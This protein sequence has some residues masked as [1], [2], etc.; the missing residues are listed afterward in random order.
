MKFNFYEKYAQPIDEIKKEK[1][2]ASIFGAGNRGRLTKI[3]LDMQNIPVK[4]FY[5][6]NPQKVG[7]IFCGVP[8]KS[9]K[10]I[11]SQADT[12][13]FNAASVPEEVEL[14]LITVAESWQPGCQLIQF[15]PAYYTFVG[16]EID[17][18]TFSGAKSILY[19]IIADYNWEV[20]KGNEKNSFRVVGISITDKCTLNCQ[21]CNSL[22]PYCV[23]PIDEGEI[24]LK[25][26]EKLLKNL[27]YVSEIAI[28]GGEPFL[29]NYLKDYLD[30]IGK[31]SNYEFVKIHT[32]GTV[33]PNKEQLAA[34]KKIGAIVRISN[35]G[36]WSKK[37]NELYQYLTTQEV[38]VH[39]VPE[40]YWRKC[41][42][43]KDYERTDKE[44]SA[45]FK[46]C[47]IPC[48]MF[49]RG[50]LFYCPFS[51]SATAFHLIPDY[52]GD[53]IDFTQQDLLPE[54]VLEQFKQW[55][56]RPYYDACRFCR[57][58]LADSPIIPAAAQTKEILSCPKYP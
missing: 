31:F 33:I 47:I 48:R 34:I 41:V 45:F 17:E 37:C 30:L 32:N 54:R 23:Q 8:V 38:E 4:C 25:A 52:N 5:D 43:I 42:D 46:S 55:S 19:D 13:I 16:L 27:H 15:Y 36:E 26:V 10:E 29:S 20:K 14:Q 58:F 24:Q 56:N 6:N 50:K 44:L 1:K 3:A 22:M 18:N 49:K 7:T 51:A 57:G 28:I 21:E 11:Q 35:Y 2:K 12:V 9:P 39:L 40:P 53:Y